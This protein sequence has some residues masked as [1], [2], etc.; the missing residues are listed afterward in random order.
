MSDQACN[1]IKL[2]TYNIGGGRKD[3]QKSL[4]DVIEVVRQQ[5]PDILGLQET[6]ELV[7]ADGIEF[8]AAQ[9]IASALGNY[10]VA[11]CPTLSMREQFH[12]GKKLFIDGL[13]ND[14][15]EWKLGNA[16]I[17][18]WE[19]T[20]LSNPALPGTPS[21]VPLYRP[22]VYK[23]TRD[24]D[25]RYVILARVNCGF[26]SPFVLVTHLTTLVGE[27][28]GTIPA[29][30]GKT[31]EAQMVRWQQARSIIDLVEQHILKQNQFAVLMADFNAVATEP[32]LAGV[33]AADGHFLRLAPEIE[34]PTHPKA[35]GP[36]DHILVFEGEKSF[37]DRCWIVDDPLAR[38][39]SDHL[40]VVAELN[41]LTA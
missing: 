1:R 13:F 33:L 36:I 38:R 12:L 16:L 24:T 5:E 28:R 22:P 29:I 35:A 2:M 3:L 30:K 11:F 17:S 10:H 15:L 34:T 23:G 14:M 20:R 41:L 25:P 31:E 37:N 19:F 6:C 32:C 7:N 26:F 8:K 9:E 40:P 21:N 27:R 18:R 39:A 4:V